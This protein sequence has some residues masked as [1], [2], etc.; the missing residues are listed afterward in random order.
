MEARHQR[1]ARGDRATRAT[2]VTERFG[3]FEQEVPPK[4]GERMRNCG[5]PADF[6]YDRAYLKQQQWA[7]E[8]GRFISG[9]LES[10]PKP[11]PEFRA[12][13]SGDDRHSR[14]SIPIGRVPSFLR[15][16][17]IAYCCAS[18][19]RPARRMLHV[20]RSKLNPA[21]FQ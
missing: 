8:V 6:V 14:R 4:R 12:P 3:R 7:A 10:D 17:A 15:D 19:C 18:S 5:V 9:A 13:N 20:Y 21:V 1:I 11:G 16:S 2:P